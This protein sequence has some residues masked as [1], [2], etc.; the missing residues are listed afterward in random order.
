MQ[1]KRPKDEN[2]YADFLLTF[3]EPL[4]SSAMLWWD[5]IPANE[6][7]WDSYSQYDF[8]GQSK[9]LWKEGD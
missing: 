4:Q 1:W 2:T 3:S 5:N 6:Q 9:N 7:N 8:G